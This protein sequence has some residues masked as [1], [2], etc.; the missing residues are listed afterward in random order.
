MAKRK[1]KRT[2]PTVCIV[3]SLN[4]L[5]EDT[6]K[7]GEIISRTLRLS[8]KDAHYT[9]LRSPQEMEAFAVEF[10]R[11]KHRYLHVSCHGN[12]KAFFT[13][14]GHMLA[15]DFARLLAPHVDSRRVFLSA[16]Q[17]AQSEFAKS[18]LSASGCWSVLAPVDDI[19]FDDAA[20]FWSSF[21]HIMFK[22]NP[23]SMN[24]SGIKRTVE[25]CADLIG[26]QFRLFFR[27]DGEVRS[28]TIGQACK[29]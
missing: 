12:R 25:K 17:A 1:I 14:T 23:D 3:E 16:C 27:E 8:A 4:F 7:E 2:N 13:T 26:A 22:N 20:I 5:Q 21:Y 28:E 29:N 24:R 10:G 9:Y 18:L 11:S 15:A 6:H 19:F